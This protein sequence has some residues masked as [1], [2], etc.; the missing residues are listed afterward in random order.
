M[1]HKVSSS[2]WGLPCYLRVNGK[3]YSEITQEGY[4]SLILWGR[5]A[6]YDLE[7]SKKKM[8]NGDFGTN[9]QEWGFFDGDYMKLMEQLHT[10]A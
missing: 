6:D 8:D 5:T 3:R 7:S 10:R 4:R 9:Q 2:R 1:L